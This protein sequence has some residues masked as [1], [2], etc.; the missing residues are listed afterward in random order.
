MRNDERRAFFR[1]G[2]NELYLPIYDA[3]CQKLGPEWQPYCG[4]RTAQEQ[5]R[6]YKQGRSSPG[7][8]VTRADSWESAHN[9]GCATDWTIWDSKS[10]PIWLPADDIKW[11]EYGIAVSQVKA[12]WGGLWLS[13]DC[14]HNE[15]AISVSWKKVKQVHDQLGLEAVQKFLKQVHKGG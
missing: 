5:A 6:L 14:P 8:L 15:Y 13:P 10:K 3:L 2:L 12:E 1:K 7:K 9:Y 4:L 11:K